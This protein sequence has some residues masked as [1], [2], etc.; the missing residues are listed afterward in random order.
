[1]NN[2]PS[3]FSAELTEERRLYGIFQHDSAIAG[4]EPESLEALREVLDDIISCG[5]WH[6]RSPHLTPCDFFVWNIKKRHVKQIS[7][8]WED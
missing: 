3:P 5:L 7:T 2:I 6:S 8:L 1:V 4:M